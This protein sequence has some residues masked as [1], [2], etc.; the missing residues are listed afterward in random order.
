MK[1]KFLICSIILVIML[2]LVSCT[3]STTAQNQNER[4]STPR[5]ELPALPSQEGIPPHINLSYASE[6]SYDE[7]THWYACTTNGYTHLKKD[8]SEHTDSNEE[9]I[10]PSTDTEK[11]LAKYTCSVCGHTYEKELGINT[12]IV[13]PPSVGTVYIGQPLSTVSLIGGAGSVD[14][15]FS[16][17]N[18]DE[19]ALESGNYSITFTPSDLSTYAV[20]KG[21]IAIEPEQ[22]TITITS[23]ENGSA[24]PEGTINVNYNDRLEVLFTP[25]EG[26]MVDS[27]MID[28]TKA[29]VSKYIFDNITQCHTLSVTFK[30]ASSAPYTITC[31]SGTPDCY[32]VNGSTIT[33]GTISEESVYSISGTLDGNIII[34]VGEEFNFELQL[35][36]F[37]L[38]SNE[39]SPI[40][41]L[42]AKNADI[43]AKANT[44][45][46]IYDNREAVD[47]ADTTKYSASIYSL[48][49]LDICGQGKLTVESK[50]NNGIHTK[51]DLV[52][53]NL[54]LSV[55][56]SDNALKGNDSVT[57]TNA[58]TTLIATQGD[59]IK[60]SN[61]D[62]ST[63]TGKQRGTISISG[64]AHKLYA[65][66]DGIDAS[67][68]VIIDDE[69]TVIDI[70]TDKY[71]SY[72]ESVTTVTE[73]SYYIRY[74]SNA[75]SFSIKYE[76][77][78]GGYV[79]ENAEYYTSKQSGRSTYYY[80]TIP[81][82]SE[83]SSLTL[84]A[85]SSGQTQGQD[86]SYYACTE[87]LS[88]NDSYDTLA[89]SYRYGSL[90]TSWTSY[91][92]SSSMPGGMGGG[93][94]EGNSDKGT[95]STKGIK[96]SNEIIINNGIIS[97]ESYDDAIHANNDVALENGE[98]PLG[99][100][101]I[102]AGTVTVSSNDDGI[103]ADGTLTIVNGSVTVLSSYEGLEGAFVSIQGGKASIS[104]K[105]DGIN[106]ASTSGNAITISG[107]EVYVYCTG[108][109]IDSNSTDSYGGILFSGGKTVVICN[110]S[111]NSAIDCERGYSHTGGYVLAI[112]SSGGMTS[113][114]SNTNSSS[115]TKKSSLS[116]SSGAYLTS[117]V[118]G[119]VVVT[120]KMPCAL[121]PYVVFLG[122]SSA[123]ISSNSSSSASLDANGVCWSN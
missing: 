121:S 56:C 97:I 90:S 66:C 4:F 119:S 47:E 58:T 8:E 109:G 30:E 36:G 28:S 100:V 20:V 74:S 71:S 68:N 23:G 105:D 122:S 13:T 65:A 44:E 75:Y 55:A 93:M 17:T 120:V 91:S 111:G 7:S 21:S 10:K 84:Y 15:T 18:P 73:E 24:S 77:S 3:T 78:D 5:E 87:A 48:C 103:H 53:K 39:E 1:R 40:V 52:V 96:A 88:H 80:Y 101:T 110:S 95:Y 29:S 67:Y 79:W 16:W 33:F 50:S 12:G 54:T 76:N 104:S 19:L 112:M 25:D 118:N 22:I 45:N 85:Y 89:L 61:S 86:S 9:I 59:C 51:D 115:I 11:G 37:S 116:L 27:V 35:T 42:S 114:A 92:S 31:L 34:D 57:I 14:G 102:N 113:E 70:Y 123:T 2:I 32:T 72:S 107:G 43:K 60:T 6:W 106:G 38:T 63:T 49:D 26:Y 82:R 46:Y 69:T 98:T 94:S 41:I 83:Y 108:D 99:N 64:G 117:S 81:K 62:V